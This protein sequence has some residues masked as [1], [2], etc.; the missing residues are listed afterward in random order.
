MT[1]RKIMQRTFGKIV[2]MDDNVPVGPHYDD[3]VEC[4]DGNTICHG[5]V[6]YDCR[7]NPHSNPNDQHE[8]NITI[9]EE[10]LTAEDVWVTE[11]CTEN[12]DYANGY[13]HLLNEDSIRSKDCVEDWVAENYD[14]ESE[15]ANLVAEQVWEDL[16]G[17]FDV[18]PEYDANEYSCYT[19]E[20][21]CLASYE[22]GEYENQ[23]DFDRHPELQR[24]HDCDE[25]DNVLDSVNCDVSVY[26]FKSREFIDGQFKYVGRE[27]YKGFNGSDHV[28]T[29]HSPGGQWH[30]VVSAD[31]MHE[32]VEDAIIEICEK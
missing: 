21:C 27:T 13:A 8:A 5:E 7:N 22:I 11:Y 14:Y 3:H 26:R 31:R 32:A 29:Y 2:G 9:V 4:S 1:K 12:D 6:F 20:G 18:E 17:S 23:V 24:L 28:M 25:L 10:I 15:T 30:W 19:G 16:K